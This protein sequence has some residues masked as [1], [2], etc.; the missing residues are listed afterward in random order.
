MKNRIINISLLILVFTISVIIRLNNLKEP[1]GRHHEWLTGHV[2]MT[3]NIF[4]KNGASNH[5]YSPVLTFNT[6][7]DRYIFSQNKFKDKNDYCYYVSYPPLCFLLPHAVFTSLGLKPS[8]MGLHIIGLCVQLL[9]GLLIYFLLLKMF[10][11]KLNEPLFIPAFF[12]FCLYTFASGNLW[13]HANVWFADMLVPLFIVGLLY[14]AYHLLQ[15]ENA[16]YK[17]YILLFITCFLGAYTEWQMLF[18]SF[19][20]CAIFFIKGFKKRKNFLIVITIAAAT[21]LSLGTTYTQYTSIAGR[22]NLIEALKSKYKQR[23]GTDHTSADGGLSWDNPYSKFRIAEHYEKNYSVLLDYS[24]YA[25]LLFSILLVF[26]RM[27][28]K[29]II[30]FNHLLIFLVL[31]LSIII[32][33]IIFYNFTAVHDFS[34]LKTTLLLSVFC[35]FVMA[36]WRDLFEFKRKVKILFVI[37]NLIL[38]GMFYHF[39]S[40]NYYKYNIISNSHRFHQAFGEIVTKHIK[41]N[42]I[43][44]SSAPITPESMCYANR[45]V[46]TVPTLSDAV[47]TLKNMNSKYTGKFVELNTDSYTVFHVN[48]NG[49]TLSKVSGEFKNLD[50]WKR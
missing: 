25:L 9:I 27:L 41:P 37:T 2:L 4:D 28:E 43:L 6:E 44:L 34:A 7:A 1:V 12:A 50:C 21:V 31:L 17:W 23:S 29:K 33:H 22:E 15:N 49:D 20:F 40:L 3:L 14:I 42:E 36:F 35:G 46:L 18:V 32:H 10:N 5:Y 45:N 19:I 11:R 26:Q 24:W 30:N 47:L 16:G 48:I 13:F 39:S 8:I 38:I